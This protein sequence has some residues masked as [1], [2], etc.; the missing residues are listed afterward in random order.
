MIHNCII[1]FKELLTYVWEECGIWRYKTTGDINSDFNDIILVSV[2][3]F[4][5][6]QL[7]DEEGFPLMDHEFI[8]SKYIYLNNHLGITEDMYAYTLNYIYDITNMNTDRIIG[9]TKLKDDYV[10]LIIYYLP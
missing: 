8:Y 3:L 10:Y 6:D 4:G 5:I 7:Y 9:V 2:Y 1:N